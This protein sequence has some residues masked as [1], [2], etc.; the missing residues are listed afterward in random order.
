MS[1]RSIFPGRQGSVSSRSASGRS[2]GPSSHN[3]PADGSSHLWYSVPSRS[4]R[5]AVLWRGGTGHRSRYIMDTPQGVSPSG[6]TSL[7]QSGR[8]SGYRHYDL[9][10]A[11]FV[12]VL[13]CSNL[14]GTGKL[15]S[16]TLPFGLT[17]PLFGA[18]LTFG[19]GNIFFPISY[20]F[21]DILTEVYGYA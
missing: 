2:P 12:T 3:T 18:T 4:G 5:C 10:V 21:D 13:L 11:A 6:S 19:A 7:R 15:C 16:F 14:I 20:I 17:L 1:I 9:V 8:P